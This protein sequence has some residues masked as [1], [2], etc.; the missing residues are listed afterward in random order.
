ME[1]YNGEVNLLALGLGDL[2]LSRHGLGDNLLGY[3][4]EELLHRS[5]LD[6]FLPLRPGDTLLKGSADILL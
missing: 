4:F 1:P 2:F 3:D 6:T 5:G